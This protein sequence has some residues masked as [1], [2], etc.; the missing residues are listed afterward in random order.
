MSV[1]FHEC[2]DR[3]SSS[4]FTFGLQSPGG[5][6]CHPGDAQTAC[7]VHRVP[8]TDCNS[9]PPVVCRMET[10]AVVC[11]EGLRCLSC[12]SFTVEHSSVVCS[13]ALLKSSLSSICC[14]RREPTPQP[15]PVCS[16]QGGVK[17]LRD[18]DPPCPVL[19][20]E[21]S[22][23]PPPLSPFP[24]DIDKNADEKPP[25]LLHHRQEEEADR[26]QHR[27][28]L[29]EKAERNPSGTLLQDV[30]NRFSEKL[31]TIRPPEKDPPLASA[32]LHAPPPTS[33]DLQSPADAHLTEIITTVLHTGGASDYS[34]SELFNRHESQE[35]KS[36]NTRSRR[37]Q[38]VL[39]AMATRADGAATR[40]QSLQIKRELAMYDQSHSRRKGP[41]AKRARCNEPEE[42]KGEPADTGDGAPPDTVGGIKTETQTARATG[43]GP[44][45]KTEEQERQ[46]SI[47]SPPST[48]TPPGAQSDFDKEGVVESQRELGVRGAD[49]KA[50]AGQGA[51]PVGISESRRSRRSIVPP[52]R[53]SSYVTEPR[54]MF[55]VACFS[56]GIFSQTTQQDTVVPPTSSA[57]SG[58]NVCSFQP[59]A[60]AVDGTS[61]RKRP[62]RLRS[63]TRVESP[64]APSAHYT[65]PI[66]LMFVS[67]VRDTD[68]VKYSLKSA[69]SGSRAE[70]SFDPY[71]E[72]SWAGPPEKTKQHLVKGISSPLKS[73]TSSAK[74]TSKP[75]RSGSTPTR[76][77]PPTPAKTD[78]SP[79]KSASPPRSV[80][81][82]RTGSRRSGEGTPPKHPAGTDPPPRETTPPKRRPGRPKKLGP[83]LE[84]KVKRPIGR[85]RK[86]PA[87]GPKAVDENVEQ[88]GNKNLKITVVYGRSRRNK[89]TVSESFDRLT[90]DFHDG[91]TAAASGILSLKSKT[92]SRRT[93]AASTESPEDLN[94]AGPLKEHAE[95]DAA[96]SRKP[97]RP[98]K[99]KISGISVTVTTVSPR[100]R[101]I[102]LDKESEQPPKFTDCRK[103]LVTRGGRTISPSTEEGEARLLSQPVAVR[104]SKR[105]RKPSVC[106]LHA[107]ASASSRSYKHSN[108]LLRRSKQ[109]LLH[110][111]SNE[112]KRDGSGGAAPHE[113]QTAS[114]DLSRVA[115]VSA[116]S[117]FTPKE[118]LR[119]WA[120][121]AEEHTLSRELARRIQL[122]SDT[123]VS[124]ADDQR[125]RVERSAV[126]TL[127][128][129]PRNKP[130]SCSMQQLS[131]WFMQTTETQSLAIV[132]KASSRNPYEVMHFPRSLDQ[133]RVC[134]S[135]QA[136]RLRKHMKKFAQ[137]V[138]KSPRQHERAQER[139]RRNNRPP[140]RRHVGGPGSGRALLEYRAT[141]FRARTRF[142]TRKEKER[143][144]RKD[145]PADTCRSRRWTRE[146]SSPSSGRRP[147]GCVE[148]VD[149][150]K[151]QKLCSKAWSPETLKECRVFLRKI[152]SPDNDSTEDEWNSCTV[153]LEDGAAAYVFSGG[154]RDLVGVVKAVKRRSASRELTA[155]SSPS[156]PGHQSPEVGSSQAPPVKR[157][158]QSRVRGLSGPRWCDFVFGKFP[159]SL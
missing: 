61:P 42:P 135:P 58:V 77:D 39:A 124:D 111:V 151:E 159:L 74:T 33:D 62:L 53:F 137:T 95:D 143:R 5:S 99:I 144:R 32:A 158:R 41:T 78:S 25:S 152:N 31:E 50:S 153:T 15:C 129:C 107:V 16:K 13:C 117:I 101:R 141:L 118:T 123:W 34:L 26:L 10:Y 128:D 155:S 59:Q 69:S 131:S 27:P 115:A 122:L 12:Q 18:A 63:A 36:P 60:G 148:P 67:P 1:P 140:L 46:I 43:E 98:A 146:P 3:T 110:K 21:Q 116:D 134:P 120:A 49:G 22:P 145:A 85:P 157:L 136:E 89:R 106:F 66:K 80:S 149:A 81:S 19:K 29:G 7:S 37:R 121:S 51:D 104:H 4:F 20:R 55:F 90:T 6:V 138:P 45:I 54:K 17:R 9:A 86:D 24:P 38:E 119:W 75:P 23:S 68:G 112:R 84:Q 71:E 87:N 56:D 35:P 102:Q 11:P 154:D 57:A 94:A 103:T 125:G 65:S 92:G 14:D 52:Q 114:Q 108:A 48:Q 130:R 47:K 82:P 28:P 133:S 132:K 76:S 40:R 109:L 79:A 139:L 100:H 93:N 127:F 2:K 44:P 83:Q 72:S 156:V 73:A 105:V 142:Q 97:G 30:V 70:E 113:R 64:H 8:L 96:P 91:R 150:T 147:P 88:D 126:R